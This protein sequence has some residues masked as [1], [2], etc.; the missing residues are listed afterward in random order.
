[1]SPQRFGGLPGRADKGMNIITVVGIILA[2]M[3]TVIAALVLRMERA[4]RD[5]ERTRRLKQEIAEY[6][7]TLK[8]REEQARAAAD[9]DAGTSDP[10]DFADRVRDE[11]W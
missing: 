8:V 2:L 1:M 10:D 9:A 6:E 4:G 11:G 7:R 3:V 5:Y